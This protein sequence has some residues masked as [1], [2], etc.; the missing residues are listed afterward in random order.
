VSLIIPVPTNPSP[1]AFGDDM[2]LSP[3]I[4]GP[5]AIHLQD[6]FEVGGLLLADQ[7]A[8]VARGVGMLESFDGSVVIAMIVSEDVGSVVID[9]P[10][11]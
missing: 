3:L 9:D 1:T 11:R 2:I 10:G 5:V 6:Q 7:V 4:C 8:A